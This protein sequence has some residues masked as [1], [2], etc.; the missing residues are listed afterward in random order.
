MAGKLAASCIQVKSGHTLAAR[1][2]FGQEERR[3]W[4]DHLAEQNTMMSTPVIET[5]RLILR[6]H[7]KQDFAASAAMWGNIAVTRHISGR[8]FTPE[9]CWGRV[10]RY[11]GHWALL[12]FGYWV[13]TQKSDGAFVGEAG[14]ADYQRAIESQ[15]ARLPE[16]GWVVTPAFQGQGFAR[17][18]VAAI[19]AWGDRHFKGGKT[20]CIIDAD[21]APSLRVAAKAGYEPV[22]VVS[23]MGGDVQ[24]FVR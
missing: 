12:G 15:Y 3:S 8:I 17:E 5:E 22:E 2:S 14:L 1:S 11:V 21:N 13:L 19:T 7:A 16:I 23:Y 4:T 6:G 20:M 10:L 9:E 24:L 18:A